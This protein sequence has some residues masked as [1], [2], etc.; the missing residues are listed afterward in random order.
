MDIKAV[1]QELNEANT[2]YRRLLRSYEDVKQNTGAIKPIQYSRTR[3]TGG[4]RSDFTDDI[5]KADELARLIAEVRGK[6]FLLEEQVTPYWDRLPSKYMCVM[7]ERYA[8]GGNI[9]CTVA[10]NIGICRT[11][12]MQLHKKALAIL[13]KM[14]RE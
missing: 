7:Y 13:V 11:Y 5:A 2:Q 12:A 6:M 9:W 10:D 14:T 3:V 1:L 4:K 8:C